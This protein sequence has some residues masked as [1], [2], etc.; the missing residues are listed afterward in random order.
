MQFNRLDTGG[1][2]KIIVLITKFIE[3]KKNL[4]A[5]N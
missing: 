3:I 2:K 4:S 1:E 5:I